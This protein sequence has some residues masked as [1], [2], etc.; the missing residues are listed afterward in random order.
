M[1]LFYFAWNKLVHPTATPRPAE[2]MEKIF[3][4]LCEACAACIYLVINFHFQVIPVFKEQNPEGLLHVIELAGT[5]RALGSVAQIS[6]R[7]DID[8]IIQAI[9]DTQKTVMIQTVYLRQG[10]RDLFSVLGNA[11]RWLKME[12]YNVSE[13]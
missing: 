6:N 10:V 8:A 9:D 2:E 12:I 13:Q 3:R 7:A 1:A 5:A 11:H 4:T